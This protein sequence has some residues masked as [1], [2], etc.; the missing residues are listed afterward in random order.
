MRRSRTVNAVFQWINGL[1]GSSAMLLSCARGMLPFA[2]RQLPQA[3]SLKELKGFAVI[4]LHAFHFEQL[5][6]MI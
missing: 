6:N 2:P 1:N 4:K 5:L 3:N